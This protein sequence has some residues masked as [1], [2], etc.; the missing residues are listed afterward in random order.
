MGIV[1]KIG[2][3][4]KHPGVECDCGFY[5][6]N[7]NQLEH[8]KDEFLCP[9]CKNQL[10]TIVVCSKCDRCYNSL[11][12][13]ITKHFKHKGYRVECYCGKTLHLNQGT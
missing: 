3:I 10:K 9:K 2:D 1:K 5:T 4:I 6:R 8:P 13:G 12:G 7:K 11:G